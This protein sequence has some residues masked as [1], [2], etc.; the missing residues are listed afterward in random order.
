MKFQS[1]EF[2]KKHDK[3]LKEVESWKSKYVKIE[4]EQF[5]YKRETQFSNNH[6]RKLKS[7]VKTLETE[8]EELASKV[9]DQLKINGQ[10]RNLTF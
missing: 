8:K 7:Q 10:I 6:N 2:K 1:G 9:Q 4:Q 5:D 3:R